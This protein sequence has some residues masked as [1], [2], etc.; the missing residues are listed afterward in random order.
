MSFPLPTPHSRRRRRCRHRRR[1][2]RCVCGYT[3]LV[4]LVHSH[5]IVTLYI[6][7][8]EWRSMAVRCPALLGRGGEPSNIPGGAVYCVFEHS[9]SLAR[10]GGSLVRCCL[11]TRSP[12]LHLRTLH[13]Y[14]ICILVRGRESHDSDAESISLRSA[15][16]RAWT[17]PSVVRQPTKGLTLQIP[18]LH[19]KKNKV[20]EAQV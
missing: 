10:K 12:H 11:Y 5:Y 17:V 16:T 9:R 18:S 6:D 14:P 2:W 13:L 19:S 3:R 15:H 8:A 20:Y 4:L 7:I 1:H